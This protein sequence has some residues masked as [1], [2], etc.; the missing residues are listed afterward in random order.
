M[1]NTLFSLMERGGPL[2]WVIF[3]TACMAMAMLVE[4]AISLVRQTC[5]ARRDYELLKGNDFS[6]DSLITQKGDSPISRVLQDMEWDRISSKEELVK[7]VNVQ[8][9]TAMPHLE[10]FLPTVATLGSLLPMLGLLG[11]VTGMINVF[12]VI[13]LH[14]SGEPDAMARGISQALL[15]TASG[16]TIAIPVIFFHHLLARRLGL[17]MTV[18]E[19]SLHILLSMD[20]HE[21][22]PAVRDRGEEE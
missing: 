16:L 20:L 22:L 11:T 2:M 18:T 21:L 4:R 5:A 15:T 12:D 1:L 6:L 19:Q 13:A 17:L 14:G 10:G 9:A 8:L 3:A 7:E